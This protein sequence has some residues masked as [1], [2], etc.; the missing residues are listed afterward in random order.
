M[1]GFVKPYNIMMR[2]RLLLACALGVAAMHSSRPS[3]YT[4]IEDAGTL[5]EEAK[6][7][8]LACKGNKY[9]PSLKKPKDK[10]SRK[11]RK[12]RRK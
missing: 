1:A 9:V 2:N 10:L 7:R 11:Q 4:F 8:A 12:E 3:P 6:E 5:S